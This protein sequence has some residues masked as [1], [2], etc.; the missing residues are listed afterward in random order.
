MQRS[1]RPHAQ[2]VSARPPVED[3]CNEHGRPTFPLSSNWKILSIPLLRCRC[4]LAFNGR[5]SPCAMKMGLKCEIKWSALSCSPCAIF[6]RTPRRATGWWI[7]LE[8]TF[9]HSFVSLF[10]FIYFFPSPFFFQA[11]TLRPKLVF[12][13]I[14]RFL[15]VSQTRLVLCHS[16]CS[17]VCKTC[18]FLI[19]VEVS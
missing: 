15:L 10:I 9:L 16:A 17:L 2:E 3:E 7:F 1:K 13:Q 6:L 19:F 8:V 4:Y 5:R 12:A 11:H 14:G 18:E